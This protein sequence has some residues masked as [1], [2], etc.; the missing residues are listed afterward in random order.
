MLLYSGNLIPGVKKISMDAF[1]PLIN[2]QG[3]DVQGV[4]LTFDALAPFDPA[5]NV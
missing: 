3:S 5:R 2:P 1:F 4:T